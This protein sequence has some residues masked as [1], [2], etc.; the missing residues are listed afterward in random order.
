[1][2]SISTIPRF[3]NIREAAAS[4][5]SRSCR[6]RSV[7]PDPRQAALS[8]PIDKSPI[9]LEAEAGSVAGVQVTVAQFGVFAE[10]AMRGAAAGR[11]RISDWRAAAWVSRRF[12][13]GWLEG[14]ERGLRVGPLLGES[15]EV[16]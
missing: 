14:D 9:D 12:A 10:E 13:V 2:K 5:P 15:V 11:V 3:W 1:V 8:V 4:A 7:H 6:G 16:M